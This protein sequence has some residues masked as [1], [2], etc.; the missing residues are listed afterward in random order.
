MDHTTE[1]QSSIKHMTPF[2]KRLTPPTFISSLCFLSVNEKIKVDFACHHTNR[3][4]LKSCL[5]FIFKHFW[6]RLQMWSYLSVHPLAVWSVSSFFGIIILQYTFF[7]IKTPFF[8]WAWMFLFFWLFQPQMFL[9]MFLNI[10]YK[11]QYK[12]KYWCYYTL[13][14]IIYINV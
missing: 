8:C 12:F 11:I 5:F 9:S 4:L 7:L 1:N 13:S 14:C 6:M 3:A 10:L 2:D